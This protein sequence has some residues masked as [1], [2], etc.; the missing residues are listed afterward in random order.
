[1][2]FNEAITASAL[3]KCYRLYNKPSDRFYEGLFFGR[4]QRGRDFWALRNISFSVQEGESLGIVGRNG[5]GKSTLLQILAGT[6][7]PTEGS[8]TTR[9]RIAALLELGSGFNPEFTGEENIWLNAAILGLTTEEIRARYDSILAFADLGQFISQPVKTYSSGMTVR[10]AF[11]VA[12]SVDPDIFII[13]EA[14]AV[15]DIF[16][17]QKCMNHMRE[18]MV[19]KTRLFVSHDMHSICSLCERVLVLHKGELLLDGTPSEAVKLYTKALHTE[20]FSSDSDSATSPDPRGYLLT[21][22]DSKSLPWRDVDTSDIGGAGEVL[23][24]R[25]AVTSA[26]SNEG[27]QVVKHGTR[28]RVHAELTS[29]TPKND[30][31]V[32]YI[33]RDRVGVAIFGENTASSN[34]PFLAMKQNDAKVITIEFSWPE[35]H[36]G[37]YT[38]TVGVGE[39]RHP[40]QHVIQCWAH[41]VVALQAISP[42]RIVH[43]IFNNP[44]SHLEVQ[45]FD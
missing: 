29:S 2:S 19:G 20:S 30:L 40:L 3:G 1:M 17:Q 39:G 12:M 34:L 10:L 21:R 35:V 18:K 26:E 22:E 13:D 45:S 23:V 16:F 36:P 4:R 27:L 31:V 44:I 33:I 11:S 5:S 42:E 6:L 9:G 14:L 41:N 38:I 15:G 24:R 32:G 28:V 43:C 37:E 7:Q 8:V 25:V